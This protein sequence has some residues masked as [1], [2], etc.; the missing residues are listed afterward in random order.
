MTTTSRCFQ[1]VSNALA[2]VREGLAWI[3]SI[4]IDD[5]HYGL[6]A[7]GVVKR[8]EMLF[9]YVWKLLKWAAEY[10]G[11]EAPGPRPA[12]QE[13]VRFGWIKDPEFWVEV[14]DARNGSVHDYFGIE[15]PQYLTLIQ[16]FATEVERLQQV[17]QAELHIA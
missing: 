8:F 16:R 3:D 1:Q 13:G 7:D 14:L 4:K 5:E 6:V 9:E 15:I 2:E 12:I 17:L 10:Q 11:I